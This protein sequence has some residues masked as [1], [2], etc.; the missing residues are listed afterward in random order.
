MMEQDFFSQWLGVNIEGVTPGS[1]TVSM[2]VRKEMLNGFGIS[3]G[4]IAFSLADSALAF[5]SNS[6]NKK[7][8]V[9][10]TAVSF[11]APVKEADF[12]TAIA[13]ETNITNRLGTYQ[14]TVNRQDGAKVLLVTGTV[15]R[16]EELWF[17][18][19]E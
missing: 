18:G 1:C 13:E 5:A 17:P 9:I 10:N 2:T 3:H 15:F 4:G 16:K 12:L 19:E 6:R 8:L 11:T 7:S 14:I